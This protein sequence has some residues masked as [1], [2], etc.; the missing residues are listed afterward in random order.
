MQEISLN[1]LV[2]I[3]NAGLSPSCR[4]VICLSLNPANAN[5]VEVM[6]HSPQMGTVDPALGIRGPIMLCLGG[7]LLI[8]TNSSGS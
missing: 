3:V 4:Y 1:R 5:F 6:R 7:A 2:L 8:K